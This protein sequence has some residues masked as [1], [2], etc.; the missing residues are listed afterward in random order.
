MR[1]IFDLDNT[2]Y[3]FSETGVADQMHENIVKCIMQMLGLEHNEALKLSSD[4]YAEYGLCITGLMKH[5]SDRVDVKEY[6]RLVHQFDESKMKKDDALYKCI[7]SLM[8][9]GF[10]VWVLTNA[11]M[12][13]AVNCLTLLGVLELFRSPKDGSLKV[14]DCFKQWELTHPSLHNK[15]D[16]GAYVAIENLILEA[17]KN[18]VAIPTKGPTVMID[19]ALKNLNAPHELGWATVWVQHHIPRPTDLPEHVIVMKDM[20]EWE[21]TLEELL[22]RY[23]QVASPTKPEA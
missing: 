21:K 16:K 20:S 17:E 11:D 8:E 2:F 4:Y 23:P 10:D 15:P 22:K 1:L 13:H 5:H 7:S 3:S 9:Q 12:A 18:G 6:C 14:I 19:D